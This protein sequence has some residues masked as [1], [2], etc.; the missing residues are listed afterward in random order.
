VSSFAWLM[1]ARSPD[2]AVGNYYEKQ[3]I[4]AIVDDDESVCHAIKWLVRSLGMEA[5]TFASGQ[6][7]IDFI[8]AMPAQR[9]DCVSAGGRGSGLPA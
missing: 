1:P 4:I 8:E 5:D 3:H 2:R 9:F 6:E 7:F